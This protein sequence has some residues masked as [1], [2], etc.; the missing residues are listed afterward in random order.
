MIETSESSEPLQKE[1]PL[2]EIGWTMERVVWAW[3]H[4]NRSNSLTVIN[5][6]TDTFHECHESLSVQ[7]ATGLH[8]NTACLAGNQQI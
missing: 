4:E 1:I 3:R 2:D 7:H 8:G 5:I 6:R